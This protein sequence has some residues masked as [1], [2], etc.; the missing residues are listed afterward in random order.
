MKSNLVNIFKD[1]I[2]FV[3]SFTIFKWLKK[4]YTKALGLGDVEQIHKIS[5]FAGK[6]S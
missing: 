3:M 4:Y 6:T 5:S 1:I 2:S